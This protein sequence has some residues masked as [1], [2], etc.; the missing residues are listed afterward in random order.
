[1]AGVRT[2]V[3]GRGYGNVFV[4]ALIWGGTAW[5]LAKGPVTYWFGGPSDRPAVAAAAQGS[6][7]LVA[8]SQLGTWSADEIATFKA[9]LAVFSSVSGLTFAEAPSPTQANLLWIQYDFGD[10]T[11]GTQDPPG[12][13]P[14]FG[15][16][17]DRDV[18]WHYLKPGGDG[19]DTIMH[20]LGHGMGLAHPHDGGENADATRF[21]GVAPYDGYDTGTADLNQGIFTVMSYN[22]GWN[23]APHNLAY[24]AQSGLGAFDIAALQ[25]LYGAN[26]TFHAGNN[27]YVLRMSNGEKTGWSAIWDAGGIDTITAGSSKRDAVIDLRAA[28]LK[29]GSPNAGGFPSHGEDV[30]GGFTIAK[31]VVIENAVGGSGDDRLTGNGAANTLNGR[32]G[33]DTLL[34]GGGNDILKGGGGRDAFVFNTAPNA[35]RNLDAIDDFT[36]GWDRIELQNSV[37]KALKVPGTLDA[38]AFSVTSSSWIAHDRDDRIV[39]QEKTGT[40]F[41]DRDGTG[42][43]AP[44]AFARLD[45]HLALKASDFF[46]V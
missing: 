9:G 15:F 36:P 30:A 11:L 32:A 33:A 24:G 6:E 34:G 13:T 27:T 43:G 8:L 23:E 18:S 26:R 2:G 12:P 16:F 31:G 35:A 22:T 37:F 42:G 25:A 21:P 40:L 29:A 17:N 41:Y 19:R 46:V 44:V 7:Y 20:E 39:Y 28:S 5:D 4:D 45:P 3:P 1:M 38:A 14:S 10:G